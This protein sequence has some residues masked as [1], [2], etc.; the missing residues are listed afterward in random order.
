[1]NRFPRETE[2][3]VLFDQV[4]ISGQP[5]QDFDYALTQGLDRPEE[6]DW[7]SP[8]ITSQG[9]AFSLTGDMDSGFWKVWVRFETQ[10]G[11]KLVVEGPRFLL[12]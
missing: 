5:Q 9:H 1:M 4:L 3:T 8:V 7:Q 11:R 10:D 12:S 2:D 6:A